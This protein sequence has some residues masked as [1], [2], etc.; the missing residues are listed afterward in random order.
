[1]EISRTAV[2]AILKEAGIDGTRRAETL[3]LDEWLA[4]V[5]AFEAREL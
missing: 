3:T 2:G 5:K 4:L 1:L